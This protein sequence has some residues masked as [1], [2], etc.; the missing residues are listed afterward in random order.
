MQKSSQ[1]KKSDPLGMLHSK[2]ISTLN[3]KLWE[4]SEAAI[5][6]NLITQNICNVSA[7]ASASELQDLGLRVKDAAIIEFNPD[8][9]VSGH[10]LTEAQRKYDIRV[11]REE[12]SVEEDQLAHE[13][14][15]QD[16]QR[17][18]DLQER[19]DKIDLE[20]YEDGVLPLTNFT[21]LARKY[22]EL[23]AKIFD[24]FATR[25]REKLQARLNIIKPTLEGYIAQTKSN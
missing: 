25:D 17:K 18:R 3:D 7:S 5:R 13:L 19:R 6:P 12:W 22:P 4:Y 10:I 21:T 8:E 2:I 24:T 16:E 14:R 1:H 9:G 23:A 20:R 15:M 11:K